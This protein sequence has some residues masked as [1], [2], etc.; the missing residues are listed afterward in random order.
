MFILIGWYLRVN[1]SKMIGKEE[2]PLNM[3]LK[4]QHD[5]ATLSNH[6]SSFIMNV[7]GLLHELGSVNMSFVLYISFPY[8]TIIK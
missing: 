4:Y 6:C 7:D 5:D 2:E 1:K 8:V 3:S